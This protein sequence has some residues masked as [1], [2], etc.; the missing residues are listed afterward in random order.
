MNKLNKMKRLVKYNLIDYFNIR[1]FIITLCILLLTALVIM[2]KVSV[3]EV[4]FKTDVN[5]WDYIFRV[6]TSPFFVNWALI[7]MVLFITIKSLKEKS[8][9]YALIRCGN[10]NQFMTSK[11]IANF[12]ILILLLVC[13][14]AGIFII[15]LFQSHF[16]AGWS[17]SI[18]NEKSLEIATKYLYVSNFIGSFTPVQALMIVFMEFLLAG[19]FL[20]FFRDVLYYITR[21]YNIALLSLAMYLAYNF[22]YFGNLPYI[23]TANMA[24]IWY[25]RFSS[26]SEVKTLVGVNYEATFIVW[27]SMITTLIAISILIFIN[28]KITR[29]LDAEI[30]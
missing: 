16:Q 11:F 10:S 21:N 29:T 6:I 24:I 17:D 23:S 2:N 8:N 14:F 20:V 18:K 26:G 5:C 12:I 7:P 27:E 15:S 30:I 1:S 3:Y 9:R 25:H 19:T 4:D 22:M 28:S 13:F